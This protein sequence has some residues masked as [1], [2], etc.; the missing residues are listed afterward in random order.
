MSARGAVRL[1][2]GLGAGEGGVVGDA[3]E[4]GEG[5]LVGLGAAGR[6]VGV[7]SG[8]A[9]GGWVVAVVGMDPCPWHATSGKLNMAMVVRRRNRLRLIQGDLPVLSTSARPR[10]APR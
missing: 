3:A 5:T 4:V 1:G 8:L 6:A 7:G 2:I 10:L 9:A